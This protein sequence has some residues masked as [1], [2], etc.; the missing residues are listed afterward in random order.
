M[1]LSGNNALNSSKKSRISTFKYIANPLLV[2]G[3]NKMSTMC[4][5]SSDDAPQGPYFL[6]EM[7]GVLPNT[8]SGWLIKKRKEETKLLLL[9][10]RENARNC[11]HTQLVEI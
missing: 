9:P 7:G 4:I 2:T 11:S 3:A 10:Q 1:E 5:K 8:M 6:Q